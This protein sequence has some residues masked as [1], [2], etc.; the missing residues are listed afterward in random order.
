MRADI[1][2]RLA[3][4]QESQ[5]VR[6]HVG[7]DETE[8]HKLLRH[9]LGN[10]YFHTLTP[11][12]S[13]VPTLWCPP[14]SVR[15]PEPSY[16]DGAQWGMH[17]TCM[18]GCCHPGRRPLECLLCSRLCQ[19]QLLVQSVLAAGERVGIRGRANLHIGQT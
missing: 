12:R 19:D 13:R 1:D 6:R 4:P 17:Q 2:E 9:R 7:F 11:E 16:S 8:A 14:P 15:E 10:A 5:E 3:G 18:S